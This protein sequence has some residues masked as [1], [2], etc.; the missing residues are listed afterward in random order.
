MFDND[1]DRSLMLSG[2]VE[3][4]YWDIIYAPLYVMGSCVFFG[5]CGVLFSYWVEVYFNFFRRV[6]QDGTVL[7]PVTVQS[8]Q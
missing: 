4:V 7:R 6:S 2:F 5:V 3:V 8:R 1:L